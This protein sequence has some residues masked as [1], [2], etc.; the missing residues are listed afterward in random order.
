MITQTPPLES[1][2]IK[3]FHLSGYTFSFGW[4]VQDLEQFSWFSQIRIWHIKVKL[5][6]TYQ[7][8]LLHIFIEENNMY[9]KLCLSV[10]NFRVS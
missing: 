10:L 8:L 4:T 1:I 6:C 3:S 2:L 5:D 9:P 7:E